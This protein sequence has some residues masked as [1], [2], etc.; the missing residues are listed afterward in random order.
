M[1]MLIEEKDTI[2]NNVDVGGKHSNWGKY[3]FPSFSLE[4]ILHLTIPKIIVKQIPEDI[5]IEDTY[6]FQT[7]LG[8]FN[9]AYEINLSVK[10][11][12]H[13]RSSFNGF[14]KFVDNCMLRRYLIVNK[15][16]E[17]KFMMSMEE[18]ENRYEQNLRSIEKYYDE[19]IRTVYRPQWLSKKNPEVREEMYL[20][21]QAY[22][23]MK[24]AFKN[25]KRDSWERYF[26][27]L[28]WVM[29][30]IIRELPNTNKTWKP[31]I[32]KILIALLHDVQEDIPEYADVVRK[33]YGDYIADGVNELSKKDWKIYLN[34]W[35]KKICWPYITAQEK[36]FDEI[37][38]TLIKEHSDIWFTAPNKIKKSELINAMDE[39]QLEYYTKL[40]E[41]IK[42]FEDKG[43]ERRNED[44]F[45]HLDKLN[46]DYL[47]VKFADRIHNLRDMSGVTKEKALRKITETEKYFLAVAQKRNPTVY[48][49]MIAEIDRLQA[50][51]KD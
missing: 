50:I 48:H 5:N 12:L 13:S 9:K 28:K 42:P 14:K 18:L 8:H 17:D 4:K 23:L 38:N 46:D 3:T 1:Y 11:L 22:S 51:F 24:V 45:G 10:D 26:E 34:E 40:Q 32:N 20:F 47:E 44:Y 2:E 37:R 49:S 7:L 27:H 30:I 29:E 43:K 36:L 19:I 33:I 6:V 25:E 31:D 39:H 16:C 21:E 15:E 35:E 41:Y